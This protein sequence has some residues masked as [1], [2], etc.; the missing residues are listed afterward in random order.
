VTDDD[1]GAFASA[2]AGLCLALREKDPDSAQMRAYFNTLRDLDIEFV[3]AAAEQLAAHGE[4]FPK[5]GEWREAAMRVEHLR[6]EEQRAM[7]RKLAVPLCLACDDTGWDRTEDDRVRPCDCRKLRRLELLGR[8]PLPEL[9]GSIEPQVPVDA[10]Q[11][12]KILASTKRI[13]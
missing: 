10:D 5:A 8:R 13:R 7:L 4:W 9:S 12:A 1:K 3:V 6:T 2:M 11:I